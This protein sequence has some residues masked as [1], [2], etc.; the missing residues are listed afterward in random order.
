MPTF[1]LLSAP[2]FTRQ[3]TV[4]HA[5][6]DWS[7]LVVFSGPRGGRRD[8]VVQSVAKSTARSVA[9]ELV[10]GVLG[11]LLGSRRR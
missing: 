6:G 4:S 2:P 3:S 7:P 9:R 5:P 10:R 1:P 11:S 8:G